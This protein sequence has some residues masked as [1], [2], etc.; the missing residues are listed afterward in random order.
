M[1]CD[2]K[3]QEAH[4]VPT[5]S[6]PLWLEKISK[7]SKIT[8][9]VALFFLLALAYIAYLI[10]ADYYSA[11]DPNAS[12]CKMGFVVNGCSNGYVCVGG[13]FPCSNNSVSSFKYQLTGLI[14]PEKKCAAPIVYKEMCVPKTAP[15]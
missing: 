5:G 10:V 1:F 13:R 7:V 2:F 9:Y 8:R 3:R 14:F 11:K 12:E 15:D 4:P 6:N